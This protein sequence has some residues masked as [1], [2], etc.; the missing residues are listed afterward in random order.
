MKKGDEFP[1]FAMPDENGETVD[2]DMLRGLRYIVFFYARDN[3]PGCTRECVDFTNLYPKF[4]LRNIPV[5][6]VSGDS[7][8]SHRKFIDRQGLKIK[9]LSDGDHEFAKL[10]GAFGEKKNYG[11]ICQGTIRSTFL[12]GKDGKIEE[13]WL[14]VKA[15]GHA[16]RVLEGTLSRFRN[17]PVYGNP[18]F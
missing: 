8:E 18:G 14:N 2:S 4:M 6:G 3:T 11:K 5:F 13:A 7:V 10:V 16:D 9:L 15:A 17:D 1:R 12:I